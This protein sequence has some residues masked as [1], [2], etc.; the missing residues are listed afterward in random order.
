LYGVTFRQ[1]VSRYLRFNDIDYFALHP[2]ESTHDLIYQSEM[3]VRF[4]SEVERQRSAQKIKITPN[5]NNPTA[6]TLHTKSRQQHWTN[7]NCDFLF[8]WEYEFYNA[9]H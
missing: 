8:A 4:L 2:I 9:Q 1:R 6:A 3:K 7:S 5:P